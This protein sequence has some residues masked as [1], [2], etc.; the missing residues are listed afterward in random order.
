MYSA[1]GAPSIFLL[2][3]AAD[4][5]TGMARSA[6]SFISHRHVGHPTST[7]LIGVDVIAAQAH[8]T[9]RWGGRRWNDNTAVA[10]TWWRALSRA[11]E[12]TEVA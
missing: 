7:R 5:W 9:K 11:E 3:W 10:L 4:A 1:Q 12:Y 8:L 6:A 2:S